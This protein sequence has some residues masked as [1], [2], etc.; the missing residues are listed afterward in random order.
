MP[1]LL[2]RNSNTRIRR[3]RPGEALVLTNIAMSAK[4]SN[5]YSDSFMDACRD[6]LTVTSHDLSIGDYW[7]A[8]ADVIQGF[9]CLKDSSE[10]EVG[11]I[12][13]FFID[14]MWQRKGIGKL[15]WQRIMERVQSRG[16]HTLFLDSDPGAVSF[17]ERLGFQVI[18]EVPSGSI[19]GR[20]IPRMKQRFC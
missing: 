16:I 14:P 20:S 11:E 4:R 17:Y 1:I 5:G 13:S 19:A 18:G 7:V 3:A 12:H 8:E 15:L 10:S 6:E 2:N 9:V